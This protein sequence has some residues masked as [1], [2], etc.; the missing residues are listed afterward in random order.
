M[1]NSPLNIIDIMKMIKIPEGM[2]VLIPLEFVPPQFQLEIRDIFNL[3]FW[4]AIHTAGQIDSSLWY[5]RYDK[6]LQDS[7]INIFYNGITFEFRNTFVNEDYSRSLLYFQLPLRGEDESDVLKGQVNNV[8]SNHQPF[9]SASRL[10]IIDSPTSLSQNAA[11]AVKIIAPFG[12]LALGLIIYILLLNEIH[13]LDEKKDDGSE[14]VEVAQEAI[15][16]DITDEEYS[17]PYENYPPPPGYR[18]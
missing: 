5:I 13:K 16:E 18:P 14:E 7:L 3:S 2:M 15:F 10:V 6:S 11:T 1:I 8:I 4:D 17:P 9:L 12:L